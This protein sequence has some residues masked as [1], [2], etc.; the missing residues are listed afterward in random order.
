MSRS[1]S[2]ALVWAGVLLL[3]SQPPSAQAQRA[4]VSSEK[5]HAIAVLDLKKQAVT[6]TISTCKRPRHLQRTA[7][8]KQLVVWRG[9]KISPD[10]KT[11]YVTSEVASM[12][13]LV[14]GATRA[15]VKNIK[16][17][18][19]PRRP[20]FTPDGSPPWVTNELDASV[21]VID[22][23]KQVVMDTIRLAVNGARAADITPVGLTISR[24][25]KRA[26]VGLGKANPVA[27]VDVATRK[28]TAVVPV[29]K[30]AWGVALDSSEKTLRVMNGLSDDLSFVDVASAKASKTVPVGRVPHSVGVVD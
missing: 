27:F 15:V 24:D 21:S 3:L 9:V 19:R 17:G 8:G 25:G 1:W 14:D 2:S 6:G 16:V 4:C 13:Q 23:T 11:V 26:F 10:G 30:R 20:A 5:D 29:G 7:D 12:V 28:T 22:V 18:K